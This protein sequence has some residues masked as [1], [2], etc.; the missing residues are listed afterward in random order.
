M[1]ESAELSQ[2][3]VHGVGLDYAERLEDAQADEQIDPATIGQARL[4]FAGDALLDVDAA[5]GDHPP[6]ILRLAEAYR[7]SL[8]VVFRYEPDDFSLPDLIDIADGWHLVRA[9][10]GQ[11]DGWG[12]AENDA[13]SSWIAHRTLTPA[14]RE[15]LLT[16]GIQ[17]LRFQVLS[18]ADGH[19]GGP[20]YHVVDRSIIQP[21]SLVHDQEVAAGLAQLRIAGLI[22]DEE[23][24]AIL[25]HQL[26]DD[27][28][29]L[30]EEAA[31]AIRA[32]VG[33][34]RRSGNLQRQVISIGEAY[35]Y[36]NPD[37]GIS[38]GVDGGSDLE[39]K[40]VQR[41]AEDERPY[42]LSLERFAAL[43]TLWKG[44]SDPAAETS[45]AGRAK[46]LLAAVDAHWVATEHWSGPD[47]DFDAA[48]QAVVQTALDLITDKRSAIHDAVA[49]HSADPAWRQAFDAAGWPQI[50]KTPAVNDGDHPAAPKLGIIGTIAGLFG[51][52]I[53][54][55]ADPAETGRVVPIQRG[56]AKRRGL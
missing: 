44:I 27:W 29:R 1:A 45:D 43:T 7:R 51:Q 35:A 22:P 17:V 6:R 53:A 14:V 52:R 10:E 49:R 55:A 13:N 56:I 20:R 50:H 15:A 54:R 8:E 28:H 26:N 9:I 47:R 33:A 36:P 41:L 37:G 5:L 12:V 46:Q 4:V 32:V 23:M 34:C 2:V 30:D 38:W 48:E 3:T 40:G 42:L 18:D 19:E 11:H 21:L 39:R 25:R 24:R 31:A 16:H